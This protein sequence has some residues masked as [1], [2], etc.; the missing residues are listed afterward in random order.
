[1][2]ILFEG[3]VLFLPVWPVSEDFMRH[4]LVLMTCSYP[5]GPVSAT[6]L[7]FQHSSIN[8]S[9]YQSINQSRKFIFRHM[10]SEGK[11]VGEKV[12]SIC[13]N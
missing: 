8:Q 1:M 11:V 2:K 4:E 5:N 6:V 13:V 7:R 10:Y 3:A 12:Y 9:T